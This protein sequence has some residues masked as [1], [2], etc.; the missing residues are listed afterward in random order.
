MRVILEI[1]H[2]ILS[3]LSLNNFANVNDSGVHDS[4]LSGCQLLCHIRISR[5]DPSLLRMHKSGFTYWTHYCNIG[6]PDY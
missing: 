2:G 6:V 5:N 4:S 1:G 3:A